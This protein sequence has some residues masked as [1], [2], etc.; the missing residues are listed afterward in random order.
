MRLPQTCTALVPYVD[1]SDI[2]LKS[3]QQSRQMEDD[4][5]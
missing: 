4:P 2:V 1:A 5:M 3:I